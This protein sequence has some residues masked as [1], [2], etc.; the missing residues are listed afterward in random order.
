MSPLLEAALGYADRGWRVLPLHDVT[1]GHCSCS[2]GK[3]CGSAGKHPSLSD[4]T[5]SASTDEVVITEWWTKFPGANIGIA[6]GEFAVLDVDPDKGGMDSL[7]ALV[8]RIGPMPQGPVQR[9]GSKGL[10]ILFQSAEGLTNSVDKLGPGLDIRAVGGQIVAAPSVSLKGGYSWERGFELSV[11]A[12]PELLTELKRAVVTTRQS[13]PRPDFPPATTAQL[14]AC[15]AELEELGPAVQGNGG[16]ALTFRAACIAARDFALSPEEALAALSEWNEDC[17]PQWTELDLIAK[18]DTAIRT[19]S[20]E[21]GTKRDLLEEIRALIAQ[22]EERSEG[23]DPDC[24]DLVAK[25]RELRFTD[26]AQKARAE[27]ALR[28]YTNLGPKA[29]ALKSISVEGQILSPSEMKVAQLFQSQYAN[30]VRF[31]K[32]WGTWL[33]FDGTRWERDETDLVFSLCTKVA[34]K[35]NA[36]GKNS[37]EKAAFVSGV[38]KFSRTCREFATTPG[39][40]DNDSNVLNT[41]AGV[42]DLRTGDLRA[43]K[44]TDYLTRCTQ[45][46]PEAGPMPLFRRFMTEICCNDASLIEFHQISLGACLSGALTDH[47]LLFWTGAGANGKNTLGDL[48]Q[49]ILGSYAKSIPT[50]TLMTSRTDKHPTEMANL[51]GVRLAT[52]SEVPDGARWNESRIKSLTGDATISA[53]FMHGNFFTFQRSH[54]HIVYGNQRPQIG[55]VDNA[56]VRRLH[57]VPFKAIFSHEKGNLDP[58]LP[59]KLKSEAPAVLA[60]LIDGHRKWLRAGSLQKC[61]AVSAETAEYLEAQSTPDMWL[62]ECCLIDHVTNTRA[63]ELYASFNSWKEA[64][65]ESA[66][67]QNRWAEFMSTKFKKLRKEFGMM[68]VGVRVVR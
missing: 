67:G 26:P 20:G 37:T 7:R 22:H 11:P 3:E 38:E 51:M 33:C 30:D 1:A 8:K 61:S 9:T 44:P 49:W 47:W 25:A 35:A 16:D 41:P 18:I 4:W 58:E 50:E 65:G 23:K 36:E 15:V 29:L 24:L 13:A 52:S 40:W 5:T 34:A 62:D 10:H 59:G 19:G 60:W 55:T 32:V 28:S 42:V 12:W 64:R 14:A 57:V 43:H 21:F 17:K 45:V 56:I 2:K 6:T 27:S 53:R 39:D 63:S 46:V 48:V 66:V 68:Y 54:K 31:C